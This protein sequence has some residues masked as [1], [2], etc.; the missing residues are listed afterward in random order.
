[1][2]RYLINILQGYIKGSDTVGIT[3]EII[4][5]GSNTIKNNK[6]LILSVLPNPTTDYL[7]V[8]Y[9][10]S[11]VGQELTF[12]VIDMEGRVLQTYRTADVSGKT[13]VVPVH[14]LVGGMYVLQVRGEGKQIGLIQF[15]K[16]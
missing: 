11:K 5:T 4:I 12:S 9:K 2:D 15:V 7:N 6:D 10:A 13:Y 3:P 14:N 16:R 1:M 8:Y